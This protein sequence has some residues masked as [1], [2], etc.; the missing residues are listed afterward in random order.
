MQKPIQTKTDLFMLVTGI[1]V[2]CLL[3]ANVLAAKTFTLR[4]DIVLP[5]AVII[6]PLSYIINDLLA[7]IYG[8]AKA[9]HVIWL[10]FGMNLVAVTAYTIAIALPAPA[11]SADGGAAFASVLGSSARVLVGSLTAYLIGSTL[12]AYVMVR[13][14]A[15]FPS[16]L[17]ARCIGSTLI[18]EGVD[19]TVFITIAFAGTMPWDLLPVMIVAQAVFKTLY[20]VVCYPLTKQVIKAARRLPD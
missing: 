4:G 16:Q 15:I 18:G 8:L 13:M 11:Y 10:G 12:N 5:C 14:K 20:E 3:I 1:F 7:E 9:K 6:F 17:F 2:G 19:A